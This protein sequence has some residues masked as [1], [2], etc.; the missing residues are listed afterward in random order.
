[1]NNISFFNKYEN[2]I[3]KI[4]FL[5][6]FL[7]W[8][9]T[10][11]AVT[12]GLKGFPPFVL[13]G[14]RFFTAGILLLCFALW[15][16]EKLNNL[17]NWLRNLL[18]ATFVL[19][20]GTGLVAWCEQ[21][22]SST[23]A[24]IAGATGPFWFILFDR[25]NWSY[26][27]SNK[28]IVFGLVLGFFGLIV[29]LQDSLSAA[30]NFHPN[31]SYLERYIAFCGMAFSSIFWVIGSL[32]AKNK[33][34]SHSTIMNIAQ[35]LILA[36]LLNG[37]IATLKS[38]WG[39]FQVA[40]VPLA[41]W[42]G[43]SFLIFFGSLIAYLSYIWLMSVRTPAKVSIHTYIN[44]IVAV[45]LGWFISQEN[46]TFSQIIGLFIILFGVLLTSFN[47]YTE[48]FNKFIFRYYKKILQ[49]KYY[50]ISKY[51]IR[52]FFSS[53]L[54]NFYGIKYLYRFIKPSRYHV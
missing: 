25:K 10:F 45:C 7:I 42:F 43:L 3:V 28:F 9:A 26:Y 40:E 54:P 29:F 21:Y 33:P 46:I 35:Q 27:Y 16:G 53:S 48:L 31:I 51:L 49:M 4:A 36:G 2:L 47:S 11:L 38:E 12:Y 17:N 5:N 32:F 8:G 13:T 37:I 1:M 41:A 52:K 23:E 18:P 14:F 15:K 6:I 24:A 20:G 30:N 19:T 22:I 50:R 44:P 39:D 34:S